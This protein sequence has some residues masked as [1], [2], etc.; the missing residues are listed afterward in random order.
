MKKIFMYLMVAMAFCSCSQP[1]AEQHVCVTPIP[2]SSELSAIKD[3]TVPADF[4]FDDFDWDNHTLTLTVYSED[5]Y[6][7]DDL[8][9][10][11]AGDTLIFNGYTI[12]VDTVEVSNGFMTVNH[13]IE[14]GGADLMDCQNG[15]YVGKLMDDHST[16]TQL[17]QVT[18]PLAENFTISD[19]G[20]NP[21]DPQTV[22]SENQRTFLEGLKEY[23][24]Q[25]S[26]L[27]T[28][29]QIE[30]GVITNITRHWIP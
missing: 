10:M 23:K 13:G 5:F 1:K 28:R 29:V 6:R 20:E 11:V 7:A 22:V 16:Y 3:A 27:E 21:E 2:A 30:D 25:F 15:T 17:G 19:C 14:E 18:L 8:N 9:K 12:I 24:R 26:V 4:I